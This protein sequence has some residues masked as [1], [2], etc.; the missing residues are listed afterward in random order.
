MPE[1]WSVK[2]GKEV[3]LKWVADLGSHSYSG[4]IVSGGRIFVGTNNEHP[5]DPAVKGDKGI[6]MC[7]R[8][9][10][11]KFLWQ[12]V[13]DK[14]TEMEIDAEKVG[15]FSTPVVEGDRLYYVSNRCELICADVAGDPK[16]P[17]QGKIVWKLD[18]IADLKV[19]PGGTSG[20]VPGCSPLII[21]D[22]VYVLTSNGTDERQSQGAR[23]DGAEFHRGQQ[24]DRESRL[25]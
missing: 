21:G 15:V 8:E 23:A 12:I 1:T 25:V 18:M 5:R 24:E 3:N 14:Q 19:Y 7:F 2:K 17:G 16:A 13:H 20:S 10:D 22:L 11:G 9:S 6:M 4:I